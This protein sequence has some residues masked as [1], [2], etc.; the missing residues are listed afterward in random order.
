MTLLLGVP[1]V[2]CHVSGRVYKANRRDLTESGFPGGNPSL[3]IARGM[4]PG[5]S[6][7]S[8]HF[9]RG[10]PPITQLGLIISVNLMV[11]FEGIP[12]PV[13]MPRDCDLS[14]D[15]SCQLGKLCKAS[16]RSI[17]VRRVLLRVPCLRWFSTETNKKS[18]HLFGPSFLIPISI[19][20]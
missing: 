17:W 15:V 14:G 4:Y 6:G 13:R 5:R 11:F 1:C 20:Q 19:Y 9:W 3:F 7:E 18:Q 10:T 16:M 2:S 8:D 12:K